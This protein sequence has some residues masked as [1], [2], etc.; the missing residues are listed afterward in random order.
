MSNFKHFVA[1]TTANTIVIGSGESVSQALGSPAGL[2][3]WL[4]ADK[5]LVCDQTKVG[6]NKHDVTAFYAVDIS[7]EPRS[8]ILAH[9]QPLCGKYESLFGNRYY[10]KDNMIEDIKAVNK[11]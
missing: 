1:I 11:K 7:T 3:Y 2:D 5:K 6:P 9:V 4:E 10:N 8:Y